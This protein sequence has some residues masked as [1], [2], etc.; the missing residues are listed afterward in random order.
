MKRLVRIP[1]RFDLKRRYNL[2]HW[3]RLK[4]YH[5]DTDSHAINIP[6]NQDMDALHKTVRMHIDHLVCEFGFVI[7]TYIP[8][9]GR[10]GRAVEENKRQRP[11]SA[12]KFRRKKQADT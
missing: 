10:P 4:G 3:L 2:C 8:E 1:Y 11:G 7:Q 9:E 5:V 12:V 6:Y